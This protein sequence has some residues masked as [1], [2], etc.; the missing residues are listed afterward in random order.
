MITA[1]KERPIRIR[2]SRAK[3]SK[4]ESPNGLPVVCVSRPSRFGNPCRVGMF[5]GYTKSDAIDDYKRY[6]RR[7]LVVRS[8]EN[9]WG[10]P[11]T[12]AE[13]K[14]KLKGKNLACWCKTDEACHADILLR[15]ANS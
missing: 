5:K 6:L 4:L 10:L 7:D 8:F 14:A 15:I 9:K 3:G 13:I 2:R 1:T 11:P 12:R